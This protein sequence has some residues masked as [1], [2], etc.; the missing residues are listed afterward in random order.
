M[1]SLKNNIVKKANELF[2]LYGLKS[3]T[4]DDISRELGISKKTLYVHFDS[5]K[6]LIEL[7]LDQSKVQFEKRC[8]K[9]QNQEID[10]LEKLYNIFDE[11]IEF[12]NEVNTSSYWSFKKYYPDLNIKFN[13][14]IGNLIDEA[15]TD[16]IVEAQWDKHIISTI[17]AKLFNQILRNSILNM[18]V[19]NSI[20]EIDIDRKR[21]QKEIL[22]FTIRSITTF[23]GLAQLDSIIKR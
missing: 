21:L 18:P 11:L 13:S 15:S 14:F 5:K 4:M 3:V 9:I 19:D 7:L 6:C 20:S 2:N 17:N 16:A 1:E 10:S 22:Y 23:S 8:K 12:T